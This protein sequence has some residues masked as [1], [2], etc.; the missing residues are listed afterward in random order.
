MLNIRFHRVAVCCV[1]LVLPLSA[2]CEFSSNI[3]LH[4]RIEQT[5]TP[6]PVKTDPPPPHREADPANDI[7]HQGS[8]AIDPHG[9]NP[10]YY[11][12]GITDVALA[13]GVYIGLDM[14]DAPYM[15]Q[16]KIFHYRVIPGT[17][18]HD[19]SKQPILLHQGVREVED[20]NTAIIVRLGAGVPG[21]PP[22]GG[23]AVLIRE[24]VTPP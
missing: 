13:N 12:P 6:Y 20:R 21:T 11:V 23:W 3:I 7:T 24:G 9:F 2:A 19:P 22:P 14:D 15:I 17:A 1:L 4:N 18:G 16:Y 8:Q 5:M 10:V